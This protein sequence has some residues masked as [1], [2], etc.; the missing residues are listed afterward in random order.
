[1]NEW[2]DGL[3]GKTY[4][5]IAVSAS[6]CSECGGTP[7]Y[8]Q[9]WREW[10]SPMGWNKMNV[11]PG[12]MVKVLEELNM[13]V[14]KY[15][16]VE[17]KSNTCASNLK[18]RLW[19]FAECVRKGGIDHIYQDNGPY[20]FHYEPEAGWGYTRDDGKEEA[21]S[22]VWNSREFMKGCA[23]IVTQAGV[24]KSPYVWPNMCGA[25]TPGRSFCK[26]AL[27]GE[28]PQSDKLPL[29]HLR[30]WLSHQ[31]GFNI[32]WLF[33]SPS[34]GASRRYWRALC[35]RLFLLDVTDFCRACGEDRKWTQAL[36][37]FWLDDP[38]V[39][40]HP[41]Y[42]NDVVKSKVNESTK[43]SSYTADG[44]ALFVISNQD[45][46]PVIEEV[47]FQNL[48]KYKADGLKFFYDAETGEEIEN[49]NGKLK[50]FIKPENYR[51][52]LGFKKPFDF[53]A[54][55]LF[56]GQEIPPQSSLDSDKTLTEL[57]KQLLNSTDLKPVESS[58][59]L[60]EEKVKSIV[61]EITANPE[62]YIFFEA[63]KCRDADFGDSEIEKSLIYNKKRN[64][65]LAC[66]YNPTAKEKLFN[67]AVR[68]NLV[69]IAGKNKHGYILNP[70][71]GIS[72][73]Q[74]LDLPPNSGK[75]EVYYPDHKDYFKEC[76]G[77]FKIGTE[78]SN[79]FDAVIAKR[80]EK[81]E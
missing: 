11:R 44:R 38:T 32:Q 71:T 5:F 21:E 47:E 40:W 9:F 53:A 16:N 48:D 23:H 45:K 17:A 76:R 8:Q 12:Y 65:F 57:C 25:P 31:W 33:Q 63:Q 68:N 56:K 39:K 54:K 29:D 55:N 80:K 35:S 26:M 51:L 73:Y 78:M 7:E 28:S 10:G 79:M 14:N 27:I 59:K 1:M 70:L 75:I 22:M 77:P 60:T 4:D 6:S 13:P 52:V 37:I 34:K 49:I 61:S 46:K 2:A 36:D 74:V 20:N 67:G 69:K 64:I 18:Y 58:H 42:K 19:W 24:K 41:Y 43:V 81:G 50:L 66:F 72:N 3:R 15:V 30:V 62:E